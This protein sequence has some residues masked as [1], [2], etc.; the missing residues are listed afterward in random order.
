MCDCSG[1][2]GQRTGHRLGGLAQSAAMGQLKKF[3]NWSGFGDYQITSNSLV[4]SVDTSATG[5]VI[6]TDGRGCHVSY[7]EYLGEV[8]TGPTIGEFNARTWE[9]NPAN[10]LT[11][12]WLAPIAQQYDQ[13][14]PLGIIFEFRST[15]TDTTTT[16]GIGSVMIASEYDVDDPDYSDKRTMMNSAYASETKMSEHML[17]GIECAP[18]E[19]KTI[20]WTRSIG[21][22]VTDK[23]DYDL[24]KTTVATQGGGLPANQSVGSLYIHYEFQFFKEQLYN[25]V[26]AQG[27][28][29]SAYNAT[30][31]LLGPA[32]SD[33]TIFDGAVPDGIDFGLT[34][35]GTNIFIPKKWAGATFQFIFTFAHSAGFNPVTNL[36]GTSEGLT[37][38]RSIGTTKT[39][40]YADPNVW[41]ANTFSGVCRLWCKLDGTLA[42]DAKVATSNIGSV[43]WMPN[44][45]GTAVVRMWVQLTQ[46]APLLEP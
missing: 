44:V 39:K 9:I 21:Q 19:R 26:Q 41:G 10:I 16:A 1:N 40:V 5:P 29:I 46:L 11:F 45:A 14:K 13:Y 23:K 12:P 3:K 36:E 2:F 38:Y 35:D 43:D 20:F 25:G 6:R 42:S 30:Y 15:A 28:L 27:N 31:T 18:S 8:V 34:F 32:G 24:C 7:R 22:T 17:H 33:F 4:N 37:Y